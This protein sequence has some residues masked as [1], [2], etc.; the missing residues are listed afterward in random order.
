MS[1]KYLEKI[2]G[3][4]GTFMSTLETSSKRDI[5]NNTPRSSTSGLSTSPTV[6]GGIR[7]KPPGVN[8]SGLTMKGMMGKIAAFVTDVD[9]SLPYRDRVE[10]AIFKNDKVLLTKNKDKE[11]GD[12]WYGFPGGG[13]ENDSDEVAARKECLE[14][15]GIEIDN[16]K[17]ANILNKQ[18]GMGDKK[19]RD[20]KYRGSKTRMFTANWKATDKSK[21]GDDND[22]VK[23]IWSDVEEAKKLLKKNKIDSSYRV[24]TLMVKK[25]S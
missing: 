18:E 21:L 14:E 17:P 10:V 9:Q 12:T 7:V 5:L 22:S 23:Y 16:L 4:P 13:V 20:K 2:A 8:P 15:V 6:K 3:M 19:G 25:E 11:T 1:N 24:G